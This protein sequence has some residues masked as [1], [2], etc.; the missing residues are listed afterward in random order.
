M[1]KEPPK[2]GTAGSGQVEV[3]NILKVS[4][5]Y[6]MYCIDVLAIVQRSI[7]VVQRRM[8]VL[9]VD[10]NHVNTDL[11]NVEQINNC[12]IIKEMFK[13]VDFCFIILMLIL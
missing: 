2:A 6:K 9:S 8:F 10:N 12:M 13:I 11:S 1:G 5:S 4:D 3:E 7:L